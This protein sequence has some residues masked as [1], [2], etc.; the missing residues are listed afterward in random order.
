MTTHKANPLVTDILPLLLDGK[1]WKIHE[2]AAHLAQENTL[3]ALKSNELSELAQRN[4]LIMNALFQLQEDFISRG[5]Y[6]SISSLHIQLIYDHSSTLA[7]NDNELKSY[8][9]DWQNYH[10]SNE[11]VAELLSQFA[12]LWQ[13]QVIDEATMTELSQR[14]QL[15]LPLTAT[16]VK[17]RW[18][19]LAHQVHPDKKAGDAQRFKNL[20]LEYQQLLTYCRSKS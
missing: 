13:K 19:V 9:L 1:V 14:W 17:K 20:H 4:F 3:T 16:K 15:A 11:E 8:Y 12:P 5:C 7:I 10:L 2:L 18:R 6:L